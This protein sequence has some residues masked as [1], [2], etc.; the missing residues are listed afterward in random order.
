MATNPYYNPSMQ[1]GQA[2]FQPYQQPAWMPQ[3]QQQPIPAPKQENMIWVQGE[4]GAKAYMLAPNS[5][6]VLWD[7]DAP[8]VYIKSA[9]ASGMTTI[10][11]LDYTERGQEP[12][13][14]PLAE[15]QNTEY[16]TK[17]DFANL[18]DK[19]QRQLNRLS[20]QLNNMRNKKE[21]K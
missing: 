21:D 3:Y 10:R 17:E 20:T 4:A 5:R 2:A 18:E 14:N 11:I 1:V 9:D 16:V 12:H 8:V 7:Q 19:F 6:V 15:P 13:N